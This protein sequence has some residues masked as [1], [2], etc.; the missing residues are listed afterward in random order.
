VTP[1]I[2]GSIRTG[3]ITVK[4]SNTYAK[5]ENIHK[6]TGWKIKAPLQ[7]CIV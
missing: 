7:W 3:W 6:S 5:T 2:A 4:F 1:V